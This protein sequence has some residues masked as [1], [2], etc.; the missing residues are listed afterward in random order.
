MTIPVRRWSA[1]RPEERARILARSEQHVDELVQVALPIIREVEAHG[2]EAVRRYT[3]ELDHAP[4]DTPIIVQDEEYDQAERSLDRA[5]TEALDY[6]IANVTAAHE[7]QRPR[8]IELTEVRPGLLTG[9][10]TVP[11]ASVGLYV[12]YGRGRFPSMLYMLAVPAKI[13]GVPRLV[14][15]TPPAADG[16]VDAAC[17][18]V[19]R[20]CGIN[21][22]YRVGGAQAIAA[23]AI[24]TESIPKV[25]KIVGPGSAYVAAAKRLLRDRV[26]VGLPAGP[27]ESV[28]LADDSADARRV[29][30]DLLIEAEH[31]S[32]SQA[33]L[34][35][36]SERLAN[37]VAA[38]IATL[39]DD[40]P[41]P[42]QGYLTDVFS[43]Y[44]GVIVA[45]TTDEAV[46]IV[47]AI[48]PEH[49][50]IRT[51]EP[52]ATMSSVTTAAEILLGEH[53]AFSLANYAAGVNAVLPTGGTAR[54]WSG[55]S[56]LDFVR[57]SGI[58]Q[59]SSSVFPEISAHVQ[60]LAEYEGFHW[61]ARALRDRQ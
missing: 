38:L 55:V 34:V 45:A 42:R 46:E 50:Q 56:V 18:Y 54:T 51:A 2:D 21:A 44:G 49:L 13:A 27:S 37:E 60:T 24:G 30:F 33:L 11:I 26:D 17:L 35:T 14:L 1:L 12:P 59:V 61:H 9:E 3:H 41:Q 47:N 5:V 4:H 31:G 23:L 32:D 8:G 19:A 57:R 28:I 53:S 29:S 40:T 48:A 15:A 58:V 20:R 25:D 52:W 16:T 39:I 43:D 36:T 10:R 6:A 7:H 22:V